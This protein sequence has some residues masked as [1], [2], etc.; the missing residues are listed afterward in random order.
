MGQICATD[1]DAADANPALVSVNVRTVAQIGP[2]RL[3]MQ[4]Q[5][6]P[7]AYT[8]WVRSFNYVRPDLERSTAASSGD[9]GKSHS[10]SKR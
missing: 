5:G 6:R 4:Q 3:R 2:R 7:A 1:A 9:L 8:G 10:M